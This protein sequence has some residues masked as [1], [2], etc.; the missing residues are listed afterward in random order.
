M[1]EE[2]IIIAA[3]LNGK[4][5]FTAPFDKRVQAY[6]NKLYWADRTFSD[7]F[8]IL[9]AYQTWVR[10]REA[11]EFKGKNGLNAEKVFCDSSFLQRRGLMEMRLLVEDITRS[12]KML[13]IEPLQIQSPTTWSGDYKFLILKLVIFG[14]FYP[15]YFVKQVSAEVEVNAHRTLLGKDPR[16]TVYLQGNCSLPNI[17]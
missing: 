1:L 2:A 9:L 8:A 7:C 11:G 10:R 3:G 12:L 15:N 14:A 4:S 13:D 16:T 5:I 6:K 17:I